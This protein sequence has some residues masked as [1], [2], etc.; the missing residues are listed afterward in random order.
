MTFPPFSDY[1]DAFSSPLTPSMFA[2]FTVPTWIPQPAQLGKISSATT[3]SKLYLYRSGTSGWS[4]FLINAAME[5]DL[6]SQK[7]RDHGYEG[8]VAHHEIQWMGKVCNI[9]VSPSSLVTEIHD[10]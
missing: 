4:S 6:A 5:R 2:T 3:H 9:P 10:P 1:Q 7:E 8:R